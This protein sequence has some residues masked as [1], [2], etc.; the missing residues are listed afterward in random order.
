MSNY[1]DNFA[2][3][4]TVAQANEVYKNLYHDAEDKESLG[5]ALRRTCLR[6]NG[7]KP[8]EDTESIGTT[9]V[10]AVRNWAAMQ[11]IPLASKGRV[12]NEVVNQYRAAHNLPPMFKGGQ[13]TLTETIRSWAKENGI[14][15]ADRGTLPKGLIVRYYA[16][17]TPSK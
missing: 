8:S 17:V 16:S 12:P 13:P 1:A 7:V 15:V 4:T 10:R 9:S 5:E 14:E 3:C 2:Q 11:G 6:L